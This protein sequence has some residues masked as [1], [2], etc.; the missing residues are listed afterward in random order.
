LA[1]LGAR[2]EEI[3]HTHLKL[4]AGFCLTLFAQDVLAL[5]NLLQIF[6]LGLE[7]L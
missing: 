2:T 6:E 4:V 3:L 5:D 7:L 1:I